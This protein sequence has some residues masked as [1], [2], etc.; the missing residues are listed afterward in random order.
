MELQQKAKLNN[1]SHP[2]TENGIDK[3]A[4]VP[5]KPAHEANGDLSNGSRVSW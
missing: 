5:P 2:V 4:V 3:A 1:I